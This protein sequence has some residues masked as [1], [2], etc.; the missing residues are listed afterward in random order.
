M[1][2]VLF[3]VIWIGAAAI[4][5]LIELRIEATG[6]PKRVGMPRGRRERKYQ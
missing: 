4:H 6:S 1:D 2:G 3:F 5:T